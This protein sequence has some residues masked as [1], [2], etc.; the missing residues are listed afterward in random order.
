MP[1]R[2][3]VRLLGAVLLLEQADR[4]GPVRGRAP[5]AVTGWGRAVPCCPALVQALIKAQVVDAPYLGTASFTA[6]LVHLLRL[7]RGW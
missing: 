3:Q 2:H 5:S 6:I 4:V 1:D 7:A